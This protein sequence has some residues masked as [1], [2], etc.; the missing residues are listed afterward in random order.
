M[1][2]ALAELGVVALA[3]ALVV[4]GP[5]ADGV[6]RERL[7]TQRLVADVELLASRFRA[8]GVRARDAAD[9]FESLGE[10]LR[11]YGRTR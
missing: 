10:H 8:M 5:V 1:I 11:E 9:A 3:V 2:P 6:H 4:L 7:R